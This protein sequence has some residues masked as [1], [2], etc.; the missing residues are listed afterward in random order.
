MSVLVAL[1]GQRAD[2][3]RLDNDRGKDEVTLE[4]K[5]EKPTPTITTRHHAWVTWAEI[6]I[7]NEALAKEARARK[8]AYEFRPG[9]VAI[10]SAAFALD[11]LYGVATRLIPDP[12]T[13]GDRGARVVERLKRGVSPGKLAAH[14]PTLIRHLFDERDEAVHFE[15][16]TMSPMWHPTLES[17]VDWNVLRWR[18]EAAEA[19]VDLL[20]D[21]L[22]AWADHPSKHTAEWSEA[23]KPSVRALEDLR[24]SY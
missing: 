5:V 10:T 23:F 6:A 13:R 8:D 24:A 16:V 2:R 19:A 22:E 15:E 4:I 18:V 20:L 11:A 14:W 17:H 21:V 9:L 7:Q 1:G 3:T 12:G